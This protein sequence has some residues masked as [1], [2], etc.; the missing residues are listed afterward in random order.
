MHEVHPME[1]FQTLSCFVQLLRHLSKGSCG[2][3]EATYQS[4]SVDVVLSD[5]FHDTSVDHPFGKSDELSFIH[6]AIDA[7]K[8]QDVRMGQR[9]PQDN[10]FAKLLEKGGQNHIPSGRKTTI[11]TYLSYLQETV[12][13][14]NSHGLDRDEVPHTHSGSDICNSAG[15]EYLV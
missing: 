13:L 7:K 15:G 3:H 14:C 9:I 6:V 1:V 11:D 8:L 12:P 2:D 4:Q 5:E 10:F